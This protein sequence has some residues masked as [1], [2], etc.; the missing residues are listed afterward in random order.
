LPRCKPALLSS[1]ALSVA[2]A[3]SACGSSS[4]TNAI[5]VYSGQHEQTTALLVAA[6]ERQSGI[7][8]SVRSGDEAALGNQLIQE[9]AN[10][11]ADVFY[12]ANSPVLE[13]LRER[14]LLAT[15]APG[16][17]TAVPARYSSPS[18]AWV[19]I[20]A[21]VSALA[22]DTTKLSASALPSS[23][24]ELA[25]PRWQGMLGFAPSETDFQPLVA[26][27]LK[28][29]GAGA[30]EAW[31]KGLQRNGHV[32]SN[33]ETVLI[34]INDG[35]VAIGPIEHYYWYRLRAELGAGAMHAAL[36]YFAP[37]DVGE[38]LVVSGAAVLR[39]SA[40]KPAAQRFL[41][42]LASA[43]GQR[44]IATSHS[45]EYPLRP[46]VSAAPGLMPLSRLG[47]AS[48][49]PADLGDGRTA[50]ELEQKLGL[51]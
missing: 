46:G 23:I 34:Q 42:F 43:A 41:A 22:Y 27:I 10:S 26:A 40:H 13:S 24:L 31:L 38:L 14:G 4:A 30:A 6:F 48:L 17:L 47:P 12:S 18:G 1:L 50:L 45:Y 20:S 49:T 25:Q 2:L 29:D 21:R 11:P 44:V 8:V 19:G 36:H 33:N 3:L 28:R 9:G 37:R 15:V 16:T 35:Q 32:Y 51:L 7:K 39:S 5:T